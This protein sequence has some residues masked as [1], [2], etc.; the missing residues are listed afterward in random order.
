[1]PV[2]LATLARGCRRVDR[3]T[4]DAS[5][6]SPSGSRR[7]RGEEVAAEHDAVR[8]E[9]ELLGI[10]VGAEVALADCAM[11]AAVASSSI[12]S[13]LARASA[14]RGGPGRSSS[15]ALAPTKK[16]PPGR[17]PH[18]IHRSNSARMRGSPRGSTRARAPARRARTGARPP[19]RPRPRALPSTRSGRTARSSIGRSASARRPI[20]RP[21]DAADR[22]ELERL[23]ED[24]LPRL[25]ALRR[26]GNQNST[27][28][29]FVKATPAVPLLIRSRTRP[30]RAPRST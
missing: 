16:Q 13:L 20:V 26:H 7:K 28:V 4:R 12:Q 22:R 25:F 29:L 2:A 11:R 21:D 24:P 14:S 18:A 10:G 19:R 3:R 30:T 9:R 6:R 8:L 23:G 17:L 27:V 1:M 5:V 15:S